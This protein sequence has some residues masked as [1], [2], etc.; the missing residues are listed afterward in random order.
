M[1]WLE[2]LRAKADHQLF[3]RQRIY[4]NGY[5]DL[6]ASYIYC[7]TYRDSAHA[8][9]EPTHTYSHRNKPPANIYIYTHIKPAH[10]HTN[11]FAAQSYADI[12]STAADSNAGRHEYNFILDRSWL[13]RRYP[14]PD[15]QDRR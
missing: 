8:Y 5:P 11:T 7:H 9:I 6:G 4:T 14:A 2:H 13:G 10:A 15:R 12:Y 3:D 1:G